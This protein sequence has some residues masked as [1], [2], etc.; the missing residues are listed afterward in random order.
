MSVSYTY[1]AM[2]NRLTITQAAIR[3]NYSYDAADRLIPSS[4]LGVTTKYAMA[5]QN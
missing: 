3:T 2:G 1:N 4:V 5:S